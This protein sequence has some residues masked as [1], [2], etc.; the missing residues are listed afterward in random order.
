MLGSI[1]AIYI[2]SKIMKNWNELMFYEILFMRYFEIK[3]S[4]YYQKL[5]PLHTSK[6]FILSIVLFYAIL[7]VKYFVFTSQVW[8]YNFALLQHNISLLSMTSLFATYFDK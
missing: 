1:M 2:C 4:Q 7:S 8:Y 6:F 5:M 3:W